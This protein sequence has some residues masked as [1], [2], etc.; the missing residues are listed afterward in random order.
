MNALLQRLA[1]L[2][3]AAWL[4]A[5]T[6]FAQTRPYIGY[7]YPAGGQQGTT[8][9]VKLGGQ[10][11]DDVNQVLVTGGGV[12]ARVVQYFRR[13][14]PQ[15]MQLLNEQA[16]D[17][18]RAT[19]SVPELK[20]LLARIDKRTR[21]YV[22][23]PACDSIAALVIAEVT[24]A[25]DA[26]PGARE[27]RLATPRGVSNPL[28]FHVGQ[29]PEHTRE[30]MIT[31]N[32][33]ILGKEYLALRRRP[34]NDPNVR[35]TIPCTV[36]GQIASGEVNRYRFTARKG[37][38]LVIETHARQLIPFIADAVPGWFQP[39]IALFDER[40]KELAFS[41]DYRFKPDP[42]ILHEVQ[43]DGEFL[44]TITD[45][46][47]RGREDFIY[48][49]NIGETPFITSVF[50]LGAR[51]GA[52]AKPKIQGWN[53][54]TAELAPPGADAAPGIHTL[55]TRVKG[56][57]SNPVSF[58]IETL[59]ESLDKEPNNSAANPQRITLPLV[60]N[61]R[62]DR[63]DD[64]D[65]FQFN[66][67]SNDTVA[68][69][70]MARRLD[71]PLDSVVK[72]TDARGRVLAVNDDRED[73]TGGFNTHQ[74]DSWFMARLPASGTYFVHIGDTARKGGEEYAYRLRVSAP[75]PDFSLRV[76]PSSINLRPNS[77]GTLT[78]Y[79]ARKDGFAGSIML[80]LKDP[81][82]GLS[83][84]PV[85]LSR[86]ETV[87]RLTVAAGPGAAHQPVSL[88]VTG[89]A[90]IDEKELV[91]TAVPAEDRMQA[92]LWRH[93]AP[94]SELAALVINPNYEA[95]RKRVTREIRAVVAS[96]EMAAAKSAITNSA[97]TNS[98]SGTNAT[99]AAKTQKFTKSQIAGRLR[100]L[101]L[102]FDEGLLTEDFYVERV[103][104]CEAMK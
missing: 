97:A 63:A 83:A 72:L 93:L 4:A 19:S 64:L 36:N 27:L 39:V 28:V 90:K 3:F 47:Y 56:K 9:Q 71:S 76:V 2:A 70:V 61:G 41:D 6:A 78:V 30:P 54:D 16:R 69:E 7:A 96:N 15:E 94:A 77:S 73:L 20:D 60:V 42:V 104:E 55:S 40:G 53:L 38:R 66:G 67:K 12:K 29:L 98:A 21:D 74:A 88:V 86:G 81:P 33:Q 62:I 50:P 31:A 82:K 49:I 87:A 45:S 95:P 5:P 23:T 1:L 51:P 92:F 11:L 44:L 59:P 68:V 91:R 103:A 37:Q 25:P 13:L 79:A 35:I 43:T 80:G 48:R 101:Q 65:V 52:T 17:L 14:N 99:A 84:V 10:S 8:V 89:F 75:Q 18:R 46:I 57:V 85:K 32:K 102:L 26:E 24:I 22:Q 58:A 100:Q 34:T